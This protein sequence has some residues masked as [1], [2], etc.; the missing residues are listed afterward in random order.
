MRTTGLEQAMSAPAPRDYRIDFVRGIALIVI[1][2]NHI[3]GNTLGLYTNRNFGFSDAAEAFVLLAGFAAAAAYYPRF[4]GG[5]A[6]ATSVRVVRRAGL[7]YTAHIVST[8]IAFAIV[9]AAVVTLAQPEHVNKLNIL[10]VVEDPVSGFLGIAL[11]THQLSYFNILP[12]YIVLLLS[13][14]VIMLL[15]R[16]DWRFMLGCSIALYALTGFFTIELPSF[17]STNTWFFNPLAW[18]LLF[19]IGFIWGARI[20]L[21]QTIPYDAKLFWAATVYLVFAVVWLKWPLWDYFPQ[22]NVLGAL[23]SFSKTFLSPFRLLHVLA[24]AYIIAMSPLGRWMK[25]LDIGNPIVRMGQHALPVFCVGSLMS[26]FFWLVRDHFGGG[27]LIDVGSVAVGVAVQVALAWFL[28]W[29]SQSPAGQT[30]SAAAG[31]FMT[32]P[33]EYVPPPVPI[34]SVDRNAPEPGSGRQVAG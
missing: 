13:L 11:L 12:L 31:G 30:G 5:Y 20:R 27:L 1:F 18:Q 4:A 26:V 25:K 34:L 3:P 6:L 21:G 28:T 19:V 8:V 23:W 10:P 7:L 2:I 16:M 29:Q 15:F 14:P 22:S 24:L 9:S 17:P 33:R 32:G